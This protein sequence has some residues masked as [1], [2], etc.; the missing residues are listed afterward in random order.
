VGYTDHQGRQR[1]VVLRLN[2]A[3][4]RAVLV[5]METRTGRKIQYRDAEARKAGKG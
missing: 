3:H 5:S 1:A 4:V 2:K